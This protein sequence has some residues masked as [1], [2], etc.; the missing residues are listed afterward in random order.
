MKTPSLAVEI[1]V[2]N[3]DLYPYDLPGKASWGSDL[4]QLVPYLEE[5]GCHNFE[6]HPTRAIV[7]SV[8]EHVDSGDTELIGTVIGS[9]HQTF[10]SGSV[11]SRI[12]DRRGVERTSASVHSMQFIADAVHAVTGRPIPAVYYQENPSGKKGLNQ[13]TFNIVQPSQG[14][15][16]DFQGLCPDTVHNR[17]GQQIDEAMDTWASQFASGKVFQMHIGADRSDISHLDSELA[18]KSIQ[19]FKAFTSR[20]WRDAL[21]TE[22]GE[23]VTIAIECWNPPDELTQSIGQP[24]L[25][26]IIEIPPQPKAFLHRIKQHARFVENLAEIVREA[27]A[28]PMLWT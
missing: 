20:R 21:Y 13:T 11:L 18:A 4:E 23:M 5:T 10:N 2:A 6:I 22:L 28:V 8:A 9:V 16:D 1:A 14:V 12:M 15:H 26:Q 7:Q 19:E 24:I 17:V 3:M 27:G 25:R